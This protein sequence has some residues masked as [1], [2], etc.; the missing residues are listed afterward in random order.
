MNAKRIA[1]FCP[2]TG[3][4]PED[5]VAIATFARELAAQGS[6]FFWWD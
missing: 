2:D 1:V 3:V 6:C 5:R 4:D